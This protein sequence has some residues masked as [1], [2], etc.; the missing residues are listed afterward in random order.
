MPAEDFERQRRLSSS[1]TNCTC[2]NRHP[3]I[4]KSTVDCRLTCWSMHYALSACILRMDFGY[5]FSTT[6]SWVPEV[7]HKSLLLLCEVSFSS[8]DL[9]PKTSMKFNSSCSFWC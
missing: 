5:D 2:P 9:A 6:G 7:L 1:I 3:G 8:A 4:C